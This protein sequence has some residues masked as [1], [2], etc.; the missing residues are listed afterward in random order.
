MI[1]YAGLR[2][3]QAEKRKQRRAHG[4][5]HLAASPRS[6]APDRPSTSTSS[7]SRCSTPARSAIHP[8]GKAIA[9]FGTKSQGQGH[10]TTYAQIVAE[11]LGIPAAH[12]AGRGG[13][14]R[15]RALRARH[16][17]QPLDADGRRR[18]RDGGAQ[19]PRQGAKIAAH[20]LEVSEE[21][22][23]VGARQVLRQGRAAEVEDDPG[24][25]VRRLHEP[26]AGDGGGARGGQLLRSA[27][28][29]LP[30]RQLHLRRGH[31][32]RHRRGEDPPLRRGRRLRQ[33]HQPDDRRRPDPR[34]PLD[35]HGAGALRGDQLR[36]ERQHPGRQLHGLPGADGDG[37]ARTGR[38]ARPSRP[39]RTTRSARRA[40]ASRPPSA[41]RRRS[42]TR[43]STRSRTSA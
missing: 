37:D 41:R 11:E 5:R 3:E 34:R 6:S 30:V 31:R 10:E 2:K 8:T 23:R 14:H 25:R 1:D 33:H 27:E 39:R 40:S 20:L 15:H 19:D 12:V 42:P 17:R 18:G 16:L 4:H 9:R 13:R 7:A 28:P 29:H 24:D 38:R 21:R 35:G 43:S 36:R 26:S 22:P 32:P